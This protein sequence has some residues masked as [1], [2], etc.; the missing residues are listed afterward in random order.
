VSRLLAL[1]LGLLALSA[2][3]PLR[4]VPESPARSIASG[5]LV[6]AAGRPLNPGGL[7]ARLGSARFVLVGENHDQAC[8]HAVQAALLGRLGAGWSVG[9]EAVAVDRQPV[10]DRFNAGSVAVDA[11]P[12]ALGWAEAWGFPFGL[13]QA[14]FAE[15]ARLK[16]PVFA[17]NAPRDLVREAGRKGVEGLSPGQ[18]ALLP[19]EIV[20]PPPDQQAMLREAFAGHAHGAAGPD[21]ELAFQRFVLV[22]SLWDSQMAW[23]AA[24]RVRETGRPMLVVAGAGHVRRGWGIA[25]RLAR[26]VP[27]AAVVTV[28]PWRVDGPIDPADGDVFFACP[29]GESSAAAR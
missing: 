23:E 16:T 3:V 25:H 13:V 8:D 12:A 28:V 26:W 19:P 11:L 7:V 2:C 5:T 10:L 6:D 21:P 14:L 15:A 29:P 18:R 9:L 20:P 27:D 17:L 22:Q 24:R 1:G 4:P